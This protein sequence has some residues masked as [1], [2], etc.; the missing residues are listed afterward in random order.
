MI[1]EVICDFCNQFCFGFQELERV[2]ICY[3]FVKVFVVDSILYKFIRDYVKKL[4]YIVCI[5]YKFFIN[6]KV[7]V[8]K[9]RCFNV[10]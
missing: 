9:I 7:R 10:M 6:K 2:I 5:I 4:S 3:C 1:I 8:I